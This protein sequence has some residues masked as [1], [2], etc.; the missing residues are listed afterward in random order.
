[1]QSADTSGN[2]FPKRP[3][4][5]CR[6]QRNVLLSGPRCITGLQDADRDRDHMP[7]EVRAIPH[8]AA[9]LTDGRPNRR[10]APSLGRPRVRAAGRRCQ[11]SMHRSVSIHGEGVWR[12]RIHGGIARRGNPSVQLQ[13]PFHC[14]FSRKDCQDAVTWIESLRIL[15][16]PDTSS[17][18]WLY[19]DDARGY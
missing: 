7:Q 12:W 6:E 8:N 3:K 5:R 13:D 16:A 19:S 14:L 15:I 2:P 1:M 18:L 9:A 17:H 10:G 11:K 4:L